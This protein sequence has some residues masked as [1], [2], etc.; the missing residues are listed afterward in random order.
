MDNYAKRFPVVQSD[1][2]IIVL[3]YDFEARGDALTDASSMFSVETL[4]SMAA[5]PVFFRF[6]ED[7]AACYIEIGTESRSFACV[8]PTPLADDEWRNRPLNAQGFFE[9]N[10]GAMAALVDAGHSHQP[11]PER[12]MQ[13]MT[14]HSRRYVEW[15]DALIASELQQSRRVSVC[16]AA[17]TAT[18]DWA[19]H[20]NFIALAGRFGFPYDAAGNYNK[21]RQLNYA[22]VADVARMFM[23]KPGAIRDLFESYIAVKRNHTASA[24]AH[25]Q[26][27]ECLLVLL[28]SSTRGAWTRAPGKLGAGSKE[29]L[30]GEAS[31][32]LH[33]FLTQL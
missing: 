25:S 23:G 6:T 29:A 12:Y 13:E 26:A 7:R 4:A 22:L 14:E 20:N 18:T 9:R 28:Y 15:F 3:T 27:C 1:H 11:D 24:D 2:T 21:V 16:V 5:W 17:D 31:A 19:R 8:F 10:P 30:M 32:R 33:E